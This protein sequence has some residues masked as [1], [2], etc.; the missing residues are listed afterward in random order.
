MFIDRI[1]LYL[2]E[3]DF[4]SPWR[5]AYG[6]D[7]KNCSVFGRITSGSHEG[8]S[9]SSPLP[10]P[11]YSC[12]YGSGAYETAKRF[13]APCI[14][15][16]EFAT[17][18]ELNAAMAHVKGNPFAK[19]A[20]EMAWWNLDAAVKGKS[21]GKMLGTVKKEVMIGKGWGIGDNYD[22]LIANIGE[23][24]DK[25]YTRVKLK[26]MH[27]WDLEMLEAVRSVFPDK[28]LHIDC[29]ASYTFGEADIFKKMDKFHLAMIE[30]PF[31]YGDIY[32]HAKLQKMIDTPICLDEGVTEPWQAEQAAE[33]D[34]CRYINIKPARVGGLQN[35]LDIN[36]ICIQAG[37]GCWVGGMLEND[38]GK[39]IC[40]EVA[41]LPNMVYPH[42][43]TPAGVSY[44]DVITASALEETPRHT[45]HCSNQIG[46]PVVPDM[47]KFFQKVIA[48]AVISTGTKQ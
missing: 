30:Q 3:N 17:A 40:T 5:T 18:R 6:S 43:I 39:A 23:S 33:L 22:Q 31:Q 4:Y 38:V 14:V 28:T 44:P 46:T 34:A 16:K 24:F 10:E 45:I 41:A 15:G 7:L 19:A 13:L 12:E 27:G 9:E 48:K 11:N 32:S 42:D 2:V 47:T 21:L 29:N 35:S 20:I 25:G 8:W 36:N 1:E 37:I 26:V